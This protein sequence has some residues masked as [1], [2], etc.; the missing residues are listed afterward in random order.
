MNLSDFPS[1]PGK[2]RTDRDDLYY[3]NL[4]CKLKYKWEGV[5]VKATFGAPLL[6]DGKEPLD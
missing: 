5:R 4:T 2:K 6:C 1:I 3:D